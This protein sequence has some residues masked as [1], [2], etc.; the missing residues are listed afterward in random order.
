MNLFINAVSSTW[1]LILF[2]DAKQVIADQD[3]SLLLHES[4]KLISVVSDFLESQNTGYSELKNVVVVHGPGSFTWIRTI[5]LFVNT[6]AFTYEN[7][8]ITPISFFELFDNYPIIKMSSKRDLFVKHEKNGIIEVLGNEDFL[9][10]YREKK[11]Y[12]DVINLDCD[13][14]TTIDYQ[15]VISGITL[16]QEKIIQPLYIKKPNIT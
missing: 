3:I 11:V 6:L 5:V 13:C 7:I 10:I 8:F 1:K 4:S 15:R 16:K 2:D 12:G 9:K 14:S